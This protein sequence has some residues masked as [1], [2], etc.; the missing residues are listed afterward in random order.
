ML[1]DDAPLK[2]A[3]W[4]ELQHLSAYPPLRRRARALY[5]YARSAARFLAVP[6][7]A[8]AAAL[9][10]RGVGDEAI[11]RA[12]VAVDAALPELAT[13]VVHCCALR[14]ALGVTTREVVR[15]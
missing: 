12:R 4:A 6:I 10:A 11:A 8:D 2:R 7:E 1:I 9:H 14:A 13:M 5:Y 15:D 3:A